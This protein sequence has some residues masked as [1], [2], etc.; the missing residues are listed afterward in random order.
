[1]A[2]TSLYECGLRNSALLTVARETAERVDSQRQAARKN[3]TRPGALPPGLDLDVDAGAPELPTLTARVAWRL[4]A[5]FALAYVVVLGWL[6]PL[7]LQDYPNHLARALVMSDLLF[8]HGA[9]FGELFQYRFLA[10]P[11]ILGDL[12]LASATA[13]FGIAGAAVLWSTLVFLSL[14]CAML[15]YLRTTRIASEG[16]A[17]LLILSVYLSTDWFFMVGFLEFRLGV[18]VTLVTLGIAEQVR[19]DPTRALFALYAGVVAL[20]Y[21]THLT[22]LVFT[23]AIVGTSALL[24]L[25]LRTTTLRTETWLLLPCVMLLVWHFGFTAAY[26]EPDDLVENPYI[27]GTVY[28]KL[29][30]LD[31]EFMR[32]AQ[33]PDELMMGA[34]ALS[35]CLHL[36]RA[37]L[38]HF[39]DPAILE[40]LAFA[41]VMVAL[42]L[43]L[44]MGYAEAYFVDVRALPL[45]AVFAIVACLSV[46]VGTAAERG[47]RPTWAIWVAALLVLGNLAYLVKHLGADSQW[48]KQYRR[49][50]AA[51][52]QGARVLPVYT[53][54]PDGRVVPLL[55]AFSF[56]A[57]DRGDIVPYL[58]TGDTGNPQKYV[59]YLHRP[60]APEQT[61]YGNIPP[62]PV[63]W[64][65]VACEYQ[66]LLV[67]KP[68]DRARLALPAT[69]VTENESASLLALDP[70]A[71]C[72][73]QAHAG[74]VRTSR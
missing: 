16:K 14:P 23:T 2:I 68:F 63:D 33:R 49:V 43:I 46:P 70:G 67:T 28:K 54:A 53:H 38:R 50:I 61:W 41:G 1:M 9:H 65:S 13:L 12:I 17:L 73:G 52:P 30:G 11:Y 45:A 15:F 4:A 69:M 21:L 32:F 3:R 24:R 8:H 58:Q 20:G 31:A 60:Y 6:S 34:L 59:R 71:L 29:T 7:S 74:N 47:S 22:T 26:R 56:A 25:S 44:P 36:G 35:V 62:T 48:L 57:I 37:R 18:A 39:N 19:R 55:H 51:I 27:W 72:S 5:V 42:Y 66:F 64:K 10:I 40:L